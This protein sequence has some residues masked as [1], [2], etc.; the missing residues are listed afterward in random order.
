MPFVQPTG[1]AV[2]RPSGVAPLINSFNDQIR[3]SDSSGTGFSSLRKKNNEKSCHVVNS[4]VKSSTNL[5]YFATKDQHSV[6]KRKEVGTK[7]HKAAKTSND[8]DGTIWIFTKTWQP[9]GVAVQSVVVFVHDVVEHCERYQPMFAA[10]AGK[11]IEV[12]SFDLPGFGE[13]G[14]RADAQGIT[15]GYDALLKEIDSAIDRA[16]ASRPQKPIFLMGHGMGG[17][18]A[19]NYVCGL[20]LRITSL[21]GL[22]SSSPYLKPALAG[23]G[24]RFPGTYNRLGKWHPHLSIRFPVIPEELTRE[25]EEQE[26]HQED[27]LI[28]DSVSMQCLGDMIYQGQKVLTKRWRHFPA[29]LPTM[30]VHGTADPICSFL[31]T[32]QLSQQIIQK[33]KPDSFVFKSWKGGMHDPHWDVDAQ[34]VRSEYV[35]WIRSSYRRYVK[36]PLEP[37][38]VAS[39]TIKS[40][41]IRNRR[42]S[43]AAA[44]R[45]KEEERQ[46]KKLAKEQERLSP[47]KKNGPGSKSKDGNEFAMATASASSETFG[48]QQNGSF[49][50]RIDLTTPAATSALE[51]SEGKVSDKKTKDKKKIK[52]EK[53]KKLSKAEKKQIELEQKK[54]L[55]AQLQEQTQRQQQE[56][57]QDQQ[58]AQPQEQQAASLDMVN[59]VVNGVPGVET[60]Q[61][62]APEAIETEGLSIPTLS[63]PDQVAELH[64]ALLTAASMGTQPPISS[65]EDSPDHDQLSSQSSNE[66]RTSESKS[67]S[68][69]AP[70][71]IA[72]STEP[73]TDPG[74]TETALHPP[75]NPSDMQPS[76]ETADQETFVLATVAEPAIGAEVVSTETTSV[77]G[78]DVAAKEL[79]NDVS[80]VEPEQERLSEEQNSSEHTPEM[81]QES[82]HNTESDAS[83]EV[84]TPEMLAL[85]SS[86]EKEVEI[87]APLSAGIVG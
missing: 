8:H 63:L 55:Q 54:A 20:G 75:E 4:W 70:I 12:Q 48:I 77:L 9:V 16:C 72:P 71:E 64:S 66:E 32:Q 40:A 17:A 19:L 79:N 26:R 34:S 1:V 69:V 65:Q 46:R 28:M 31:A 58:Q 18:L 15:G 50:N 41:R 39:I 49:E 43:I 53:P 83:S 35:H 30:L 42:S 73:G 13:T 76:S 14:V 59:V 62:L 44:Q 2:G 78:E 60:P 29:Q 38:M 10:F 84:H 52:A 21:A 27:G 23:A 11:G 25:V 37:E 74:S 56:Q 47:Q 51:G 5:F 80:S 45:E 85:P 3:R 61:T 81:I 6:P 86:M 82:I 7:G 68:L 24:S 36:A 33:L 22:I 57:L 67:L 87:A